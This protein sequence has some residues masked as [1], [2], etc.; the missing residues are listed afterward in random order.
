MEGFVRL[1]KTTEGKGTLIPLSDFLDSKKLNKHLQQD[2]NADW[3]TSLYVLGK[4]AKV[5]FDETQ[6]IKGYQGPAYTNNLVFDIDCKADL[7]QARKD[8][9]AL[10]TRLSKEVGLGKDG[11]SKHVRVYFSGS[12]GF[13]VFVKTSKQFT[14]EELKDC[15][16]AIAGDISSFDTVVYNR[17]RLFRLPNTKHKTSGLYKIPVSLSL[18]KK[19]GGSEDIKE[20]AKEPQVEEDL[21]IPLEDMTMV[22]KY[23]EFKTKHV[24]N[25]RSV[26]VTDAEEVNGIRGLENID[27]KRTKS[28]P[29]CLYA[30]SQGVMVPGRGERHHV[31]LHLANYY[32]NQGHSAEVVEGI[33][34]GIAKSNAALY[35][36]HDQFPADEI[37]NS[38]IQM[39]FSDNK[40]NVGGWGVKA[41]DPIFLNYCKS[42]H[43]GQKC[44]IHDKKQHKAVVQITDVADDFADF[45]ANF[46]DN[47]IPLGIP[48]VDKHMKIT[49]GTTNL[50]VG[51]SGVGKTQICFSAM[52]HAGE[53]GLHSYFASMD[54]HKNLVFQ[55]L[56]QRCGGYDSEAIFKAFKNR[57]IKTIEKMK[58][59]VYERFNHTYMDFSGSLSLDDLEQRIDETEQ[60]Y[61]HKIDLV[62][63]DYASRLSGPYSDRFQN[64]SYNAI[65]SKDTADRVNAAFIILN[66]ISRA[67]GDGSTPLRSK[68][69]AKGSSDFEESSSNVL[70]L[71][72][73]F[74]GLDGL[75]CEEFDQPFEDKYLRMFMAKNR[76]GEEKELLLHWVGA[77]GKIKQ[78]TEEE[79]E[80][81]N[82]TVKPME[83]KTFKYKKG[84]M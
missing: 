30:L 11:I 60:K 57:D 65:K 46:E 4:E 28:I 44:A 22:D 63:I 68:R 5:L 75:Y 18:I 2:P 34:N 9:V 10:L 70:T 83:A 38:V 17:T 50:L 23:V 39:A 26:I 36:E 6:S 59:A 3:Y 49:R 19:E 12:K 79:L 64:E 67:N 53:K 20:L 43:N 13:H 29:K 58:E 62:V 81:Y 42:I 16:T 27:F 76:M 15:C 82:R 72:R 8:T 71:W 73:P 32:R 24:N 40:I 31:F 45:A 33:L 61:G 66:Q 7:E 51:G 48:F 78:L 54:M 80:E 35:P 77:S 1:N 69:V 41:E 52:E 55:R 47:V 21:T 84:N 37:K 56:I 25:K 74:L 14:P